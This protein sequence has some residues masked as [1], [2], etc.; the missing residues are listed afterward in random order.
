M[1]RKTLP[2]TDDLYGY[3]MEVYGREPDLMR[4]LR[5]ETGRLENARMQISPEQGR[6]MTLFVGAMGARKALEIG[7]FTGYSALCIAL[8]LVDDGRLIT[9][10]VD[11]EW[12]SFGRRYW[13]EAG[14][15]HKIGFRPGAASDTLAELLDRALP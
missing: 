9:L 4:R 11:E 5:E 14:I 3:Y 6:F 7:T 13:S 12:P 15:G 8:G 2:L 10:D 1:T